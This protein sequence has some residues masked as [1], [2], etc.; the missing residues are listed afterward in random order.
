MSGGLSQQA[1][2]KEYLCEHCLTKILPGEQYCREHYRVGGSFPGTKSS[3]ESRIFCF[4]CMKKITL[5]DYY[6]IYQPEAPE[7]RKPPL[8]KNKKRAYKRE[9]PSHWI[10]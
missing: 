10:E 9:Y 3:W 7:K 4:K 6:D 5:K 2:M 1:A 8:P